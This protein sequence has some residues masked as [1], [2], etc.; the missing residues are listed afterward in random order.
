M[1][2]Q[3][4]N[5]DHEETID[6]TEL[7]SAEESS[8]SMREVS[9]FDASFNSCAP[10]DYATSAVISVPPSETALELPVH[11]NQ[12]LMDA[13]KRIKEERES[14]RERIE[15]M[16]RHRDQVSS[17]VYTKVREDY[18]ASYQEITQHYFQKKHLID[19]ELEKLYEATREINQILERHRT[20]LEEAKF[21]HFLGEFSDQKYKALEAREEKEIYRNGQMV[22][23][24]Q[25]YI[26]CYES[27]L[28]AADDDPYIVQGS[29]KKPAQGPSA[30]S[31][32]KTSLSSDEEPTHI[33]STKAKKKE[34]ASVSLN[35]SH[36]ARYLVPARS[37]VGSATDAGLKAMPVAEDRSVSQVSLREEESIAD[38]LNSIPIETVAPRQTHEEMPLDADAARAAK[39]T[40]LDTGGEPINFTEMLIQK[41]VELGRL[42]TNDVSLPSTKVSRKHAQIFI[43][44]GEYVIVDLGSANGVY[45]NNNRVEESLL[46]DGD[47]IGI[48]RYKLQFTTL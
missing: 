44:D 18:I 38:I 46:R 22:E 41:P 20:S 39:L 29:A 17:S 30:L 3:L 27:L 32:T 2:L 23:K 14:L 12:P 4:N 7:S 8:V 33:A 6:S 37:D 5:S 25:S 24:L 31:L 42:P 1:N 28:T 10:I 26:G 35:L 19:A 15:K 13:A 11:L 43:R 48:G 45:V 36:S 34:E 21:R 40:V 16:D 9:S 47:V